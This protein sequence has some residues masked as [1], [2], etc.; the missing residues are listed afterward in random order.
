MKLL[1]GPLPWPWRRKLARPRAVAVRGGHSFFAW[2][3]L[4]GQWGQGLP[5]NVRSWG[6][7]QRGSLDDEAW[8]RSLRNLELVGQEALAVLE[9]D[10]YQVF[11]LPAPAVPSEEMKAAARWQIK[12]LVEGRVED[13]TLDVMRVGDDSPRANHEV[14]VIAAPN[15]SIQALCATAELAGVQP[16]VVDVWE[17]ALRNLQC[18]Q[19]R[20][21]QLEQ[22]ACAALLL[23]P[24][25]CL[26]TICANGELCYT[27]RLD[28]DARLIEQALGAAPQAPAA[29]PAPLGFEYMPGDEL[30]YDEPAREESALIIE[31]HRSIDVWERSWP[32]L[33]LARLYL[34]SAT[35]GEA[36]A[37]LM[38]RE[39]GLRTSALDLHG[40]FKGLT[41]DGA[42]AEDLHACVPLLGACLREESRPI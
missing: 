37:A 30:G 10:D 23:Q 25:Q 11:K 33:P 29:E 7:L 26:L 2:V 36:L 32:D 24:G 28:A 41:L 35:H 21:D 14:F 13:L 12:D 18:A 15:S 38:Q 39:L 17:T 5:L 8:G 34:L 40:L 9:A 42:S 3:Q 27:R 1:S 20:Q 4:S 16:V 19:A 31:L 6:C 22:R